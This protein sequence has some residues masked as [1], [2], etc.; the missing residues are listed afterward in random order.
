MGFP[1]RLDFDKRKSYASLLCTSKGRSCVILI[2]LGLGVINIAKV[3][4]TSSKHL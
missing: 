4:N 3:I 1:E 2:I